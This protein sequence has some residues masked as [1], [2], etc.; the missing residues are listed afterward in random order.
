MNNKS[1]IILNA[2]IHRVM[3]KD[4]ALKMKMEKKLIELIT[5]NI[6]LIVYNFH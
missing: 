5:R 3:K 2:M 4:I 1:R 6:M